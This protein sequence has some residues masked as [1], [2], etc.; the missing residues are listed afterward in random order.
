MKDIAEQLKEI[1]DK[2]E[3]LEDNIILITNQ[4]SEY[5]LKVSDIEHHI[6]LSKNKT[7][8]DGFAEYALLRETLRERRI[9]KNNYKRIQH[10]EHSLLKTLNQLKKDY[11]EFEK[12]EERQNNKE[13]DYTVKVLTDR[14]GEKIRS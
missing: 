10:M 13:Y 1:M 12:F 11:K 14:Y 3:E 4:R 5:D 7:V 9:I 2:I 6:E 8:T